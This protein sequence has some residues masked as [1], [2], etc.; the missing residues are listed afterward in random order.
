MD[1]RETIKEVAAFLWDAMTEERGGFTN[2]TP[3]EVVTVNPYEHLADAGHED[4]TR[5]EL[6]EAIDLLATQINSGQTAQLQA[7]RQSV[8]QLPA[9]IASDAPP[10]P[11]PP[12]PVTHVTQKHVTVVNESKTQVTNEGDTNIDN[13]VLTQINAR[14]DV[15]FDQDVDT[16]TVIADDGGVAIGGDLEDS[17]V[18]T[19]INTGIV[20]GDDAQLQ[21]SIV[22]DGNDQVNDTEAGAVATDSG[23][24]T[25]AEGE[26]VNLGSGELTDVDSAGDSQVVT[27]NENEA[28][29]SVEVEIAIPAVPAAPV[30]AEPV[31]PVP[32]EPVA[33]APLSEPPLAEPSIAEPSITEPPPDP[34]VE[35]VQPLDQPF[36]EEPADLFDDGLDQ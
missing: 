14:G 4:I 20:A 13:S 6:L 25:N 31:A 22:G 9:Q 34:L 16:S 29:G 24:A 36:T 35:D 18:N 30:V 21:D 19:G 27:G 32:P 33:E 8:D 10:P 12:A 3:I 5:E 17:A 26:N 2:P 23:S 28:N 15:S 11:A 7:L 1:T